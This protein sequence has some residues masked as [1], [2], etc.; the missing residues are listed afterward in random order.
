M[1]ALLRKIEVWWIVNV[2]LETDPDWAD[3]EVDESGIVPGPVMMLQVMMD[4][5]LGDDEQAEFYIELYPKVG[6]AVN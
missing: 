1:V 6:D 4:I 2:E 3:K 5:A